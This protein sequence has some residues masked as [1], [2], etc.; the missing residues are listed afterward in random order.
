MRMNGATQFFRGRFQL[1]GNARFSDQFCR[2]R[3]DDVHAQDFVVFLLADD[4]YEAFFFAK[5]AC[6]AR[7]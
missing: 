2:M 4:L 5:Y 7:S 3:P 1:H 6:L